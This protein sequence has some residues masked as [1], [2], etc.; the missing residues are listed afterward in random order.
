MHFLTAGFQKRV[1]NVRSMHLMSFRKGMLV[2]SKEKPKAIFRFDICYVIDVERNAQAI[3]RFMEN[4]DPWFYADVSLVGLNHVRRKVHVWLDFN[5]RKRSASH[6]SRNFT[7]TRTASRY[8]PLLLQRLDELAWWGRNNHTVYCCIN[9][10][11]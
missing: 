2:F 3:F 11:G 1:R 8:R 9:S 5:V 4:M 7:S 6:V 10:M